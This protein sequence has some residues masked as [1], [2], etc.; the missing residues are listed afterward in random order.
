MLLGQ[1]DHAHTI[2][3]LGRQR[4]ALSCHL[5]AVQGVRQLDQDTGSVSHQL[6]RTYRTTVVEILKNLESILDDGMALFAADMGY[7][8]DTAGI[9]L[10]GSGI[11]TVVFEV[12]DFC[13]RRHG[14]LLKITVD[15]KNTAVQQ[16]CQA[17]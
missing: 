2:F 17:K 3:T 8:T 12:L 4:N 13:C 9:V 15:E 7:K 1:K 10:V 6:V 11:Q 16:R 5:F 14:T